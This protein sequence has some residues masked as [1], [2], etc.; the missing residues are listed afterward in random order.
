MGIRLLDFALRDGVHFGE[1]GIGLEAASPGLASDGFASALISAAA[2]SGGEPD[3]LIAAFEGDLRVS[4][5][6][7]RIGE[8][9]F[10]PRPQVLPDIEGAAP[11]KSLKRLAFVDTETYERWY[12]K[13]ELADQPTVDRLSAA[14]HSVYREYLTARVALTRTT[15]ESDFYQMSAYRFT[16]VGGARAGLYA[17]IDCT[18]EQ[19]SLIERSLAAL[20]VYGI[21]GKRSSG[22]GAF[23]WS[24][25]EGEAPR[26]FERPKTDGTPVMLLSTVVPAEADDLAAIASRGAYRIVEVRGW[27]TSA[28]VVSRRRRSLRALAQGS[29]LPFEPRGRVVDCAPVDFSSHPV[30]RVTTGLGIAFS[31][32]LLDASRGQREGGR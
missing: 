1:K 26:A 8:R 31:K 6:F 5:L 32:R 15:Q 10:V 23:E 24:W 17:V 12:I 25:S 16:T 19:R 4:G 20:A 21:G 18:D 27:V 13:E 22:Y 3:D 7:P 2:R 9:R 29:V 14:L 11:P 30:V 28:G